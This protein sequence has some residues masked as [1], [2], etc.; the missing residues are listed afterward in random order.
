MDSLRLRY[1]GQLGLQGVHLSLYV[2]PLTHVQYKSILGSCAKSGRRSLPVL[3]PPFT[4]HGPEHA[5]SSHF[6][7]SI[8]L[9]TRSS[10]IIVL[11]THFGVWRPPQQYI[12]QYFMVRDPR[13]LHV[14]Q[15]T[16]IGVQERSV[17]LGMACRTSVSSVQPSGGLSDL[18]GG[19]SPQTTLSV[20]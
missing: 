14:T 12:G 11:W 5:S 3:T 9:W 8:D 2:R 17:G 7:K 13:T 6:S 1:G 16:P 18:D 20:P 4:P 19:W 10:Y 15:K